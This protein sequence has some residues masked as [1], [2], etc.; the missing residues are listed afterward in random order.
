MSCATAAL[1]AIRCRASRDPRSTRAAAPWRGCCPLGA[2]DP[3]TAWSVARRFPSA[4]GAP[5]SGA[6][7]AGS[8]LATLAGSSAGSGVRAPIAPDSGMA[9]LARNPSVA[10]CTAA[11]G[12]RVAGIRSVPSP[13]MSVARLWVSR[14]GS[15]RRRAG[16]AGCPFGQE[17]A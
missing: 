2:L 6:G 1:P 12:P 8:G 7:D 5:A 17:G 13:A 10:V 15:A 16:S 4:A 11:S 9:S 14:P 3:P